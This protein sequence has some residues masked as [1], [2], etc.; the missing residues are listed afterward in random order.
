MMTREKS[1]IPKAVSKSW[2]ASTRK[3]TYFTASST[4]FASISNDISSELYALGF[5]QSS[6]TSKTQQERQCSLMVGRRLDDIGSENRIDI[7]DQVPLLEL[8]A[9]GIAALANENGRM[10]PSAG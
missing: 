4:T 5:K 3:I 9:E 2:L 7:V 10:V 8:V 1:Y 6:C